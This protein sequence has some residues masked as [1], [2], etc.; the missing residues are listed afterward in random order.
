MHISSKLKSNQPRYSLCDII[1]GIILLALVIDYVFMFN[2]IFIMQVQSKSYCC[3]NTH[4]TYNNFSVE[5][6]GYEQLTHNAFCLTAEDMRIGFQMLVKK[7]LKPYNNIIPCGI[8]NVDI[9]NLT[10][11]SNKNYGIINEIIIK[12]FK[13]LFDQS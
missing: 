9:T 7:I 13:I 6:T 2:R 1:C 10:N 12:N 3:C 5:E 4:I 8:K 11:I